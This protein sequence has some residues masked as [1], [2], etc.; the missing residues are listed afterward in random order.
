MSRGTSFVGVSRVIVFERNTNTISSAATPINTITAIAKNTA[1]MIVVVVVLI[2]IVVLVVVV[3]FAVTVQTV[4]D[5]DPGEPV[6][7]LTCVA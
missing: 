5:I 2:L 3:V 1:I 7:I 4:D 6:N